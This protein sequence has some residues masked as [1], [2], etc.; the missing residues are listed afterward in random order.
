MCFRD[1]N[2]SKEP[3]VSSTLITIISRKGDLKRHKYIETRVVATLVSPH[4]I[5]VKSGVP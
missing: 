5:E 3:I 1:I 4:K 2:E